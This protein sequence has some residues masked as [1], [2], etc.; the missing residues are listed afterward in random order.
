MYL[1]VMSVGMYF[2]PLMDGLVSGDRD[3][4]KIFEPIRDI[5]TEDGGPYR[6]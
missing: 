3:V 5:E 6:G 1:G 4:E 2:G